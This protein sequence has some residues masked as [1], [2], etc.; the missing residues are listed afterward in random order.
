M[1]TESQR[2]WSEET[3]AVVTGANRGIGLEITRQLADKGITVIMTAR[4]PQEELSSAA[5]TFL[6]EGRRNVVFHTLDIDQPQSV[7]EF[8]QWLKTKAGFVDILV[9][10]AG[11]AKSEVDWEFVQKNNV[12]SATI[13]GDI[14][15]M[16]GISEKYESAKE[17]IGTNYYGTKRVTEALVPLLRP[18][19]YQ[20]RI[21][22]I[23]SLLGLLSFLRDEEVR[24]ELGDV[25][26]L[27]EEKIER[28]LEAF[29]ED[30]KRERKLSRWPHKFPSYALSKVALNAYTRVLARRLEG[31]ACVNSVH[32]G[33]VKTDMTLG[34]GDLSPSQGAHHVVSLALSPPPSP[35]AHNFLQHHQSSF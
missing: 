2:W 20:P 17:C 16:D 9:N 33:Y 32:P 22:N 14:R 1:A 23:S 30:V 18:S 13:I 11:V 4:K 6:Q 26:T 3:V 31:K 12:D 24:K 34:T 7:L 35:S 28:V 15:W 25:E 5:G 8:V 29:L 21:V 10:N 27:S 19:S